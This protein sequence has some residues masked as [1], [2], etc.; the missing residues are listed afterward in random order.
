MECN[1]SCRY[2]ALEAKNVLSHGLCAESKQVEQ[3]LGVHLD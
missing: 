3:F 1:E 2:E